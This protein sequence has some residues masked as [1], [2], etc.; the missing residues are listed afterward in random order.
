MDLRRNKKR[1][2]K[3]R[4]MLETQEYAQAQDAEER[5]QR[6]AQTKRR[7]IYILGIINVRSLHLHDVIG[8][9]LPAQTL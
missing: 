7:Y 5:R 2:L 8:D 6:E 9:N 4:E 3:F 1:S